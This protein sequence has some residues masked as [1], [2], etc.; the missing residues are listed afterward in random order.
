M[1]ER[2]GIDTHVGFRG[3]THVPRLSAD[4][5]MRLAE[6][7]P[8]D[9]SD[10]MRGAYTLDP[11]IRPLWPFPGRIA[12]PAVTVVVPQ[13][14]LNPIKYAME[15][16]HP[17]DVMVV[18]ARGIAAFAVWGGNVSKGMKHRGCAGVVIDG[19]A[20]DPEE[21]Q[22]VGFPIFA[23]TQATASPPYDGA[24]EVNVAVACG[25]VVVR[26]GD[27]I[28]ADVN[29]IAAVPQE[30]AEW[31]LAQVADLR[32]RFAKIQPVLERGEVTTIAAIT[33]GLRRQGFAI[34]GQVR[35]E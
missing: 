20:R 17:G 34:D 16:T 31:V 3:F 12:G 7:A 11:T 2:I 8:P 15:Q 5:I 21:A 26:P 28:V 27:I 35:T 1:S 19:A 14:S 6:Y 13:G 30:A 24:G 18:N 4:V 29:G 9:L 10:V 25:G 22:A 32:A 33:D 23:R